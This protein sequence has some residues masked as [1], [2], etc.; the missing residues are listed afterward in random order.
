[1]YNPCRIWFRL[2]FVWFA[3]YAFSLKPHLKF[4]HLLVNIWLT[5]Y[6]FKP[7]CSTSEIIVGPFKDPAIG[8]LPFLSPA[9]SIMLLAELSK[10]ADNSLGEHNFLEF[11]FKPSSGGNFISRF[12]AP[13][14][15]CNGCKSQN[16]QVYM[17]LRGDS[18][19][20]FLSEN[21]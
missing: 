9:S 16:S 6:K 14:T 15:Y 17:K 21:Q 18:K 20:W 3:G 2:I 8:N 12:Y 1:M 19:Y 10:L 5:I 7:P 13:I 11:S 4:I